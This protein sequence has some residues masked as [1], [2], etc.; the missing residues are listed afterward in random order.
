MGR[1]RGLQVRGRRTGR[2][3][4]SLSAGGGGDARLCVRGG[5]PKQPHPLRRHRHRC[6]RSCCCC[7]VAHSTTCVR[8]RHLTH[9]AGHLP[10]LSTMFRAPQPAAH[11]RLHSNPNCSV[12]PTTAGHVATLVGSDPATAVQAPAGLITTRDG[13]TLFVLQDAPRVMLRRIPLLHG[14]ASAVRSSRP[15][16]RRWWTPI[17]PF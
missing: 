10:R 6:V 8:E 15:L 17:C 5:P 14:G 4:V 1:V 12:P 7:S 2:G 13:G 11:A 9:A 3:Q 16:I